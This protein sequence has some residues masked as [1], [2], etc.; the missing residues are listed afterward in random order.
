MTKLSF[1]CLLSVCSMG[2]LP[3]NTRNYRVSEIFMWSHCW[4][5]CGRALSAWSWKLWIF[6]VHWH[7]RDQLKSK[8][9]RTRVL[10]YFENDVSK[11]RSIVRQKTENSFS[12][13]LV[14]KI[15]S[16]VIKNYVQFSFSPELAKYLIAAMLHI[17]RISEAINLS[18][19]ANFSSCG[20]G[21]GE[22]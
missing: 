16:G 20:S 19:E 7:G 21:I 12:N 4:R 6:R 9:V 3:Q 5:V 17:G 1:D 18:S 13:M 2:K 15:C 22:G 11:I 14:V 10:H 8:V